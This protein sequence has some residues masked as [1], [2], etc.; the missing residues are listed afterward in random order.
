MRCPTS[1]RTHWSKIKSDHRGN[2]GRVSVPLP[3]VEDVRTVFVLSVSLATLAGQ[4][5][6]PAA[7]LPKIKSETLT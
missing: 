6:T 7:S 3:E 2:S 5:T 4:P 1:K